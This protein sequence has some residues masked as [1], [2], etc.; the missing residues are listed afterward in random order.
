MCVVWWG[1]RE[2]SVKEQVNKSSKKV[3]RVRDVEI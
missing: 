3:E 2:S 1:E